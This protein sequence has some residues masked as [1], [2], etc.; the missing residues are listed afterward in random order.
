MPALDGCTVAL[1]D[2]RTMHGVTVRF[3][4]DGWVRVGSERPYH[5][6]PPHE[7]QHVMGPETPPMEVD[8]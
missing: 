1:D 5:Y 3:R 8:Q 2:G 4:D 6:Y 7:V